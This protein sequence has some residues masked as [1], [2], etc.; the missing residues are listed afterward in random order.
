MS[1]IPY[2]TLAP[3]LSGQRIMLIGGA[4]F[5]GHNLA[6]ELA[7]MGAT[8]MIVDNLMVNSLIENSFVEEQN[9]VQRTAY[10]NFLNE[11]FSLLRAAHVLDVVV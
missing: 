2:E 8:V 4:G 7:R 11:R 6:L 9:P 5:I 3:K 1:H 10:R